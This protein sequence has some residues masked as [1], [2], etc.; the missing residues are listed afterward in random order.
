MLR[1]CSRLLAYAC[2]LFSVL[3]IGCGRSNPVS[4]ISTADSGIPVIELEYDPGSDWNRWRGPRGDGTAI[5]QSL[6]TEWDDSTNLRWR[7]DVPGRG[8]GSPIVIGSEVYLA[9]ANDE[10]QQQWVL[11]YDRETG[12]ELWRRLIHE[13]NFPTAR[14]VHK[15]ATN[16]NGTIASDGQ[17]LY[18]GMLNAG[19]I[20]ATA[21]DRG[22]KILW[23][24][25]A[26]KFVSRFGYAPSPLIYKSLVIFPADNEGGG[27]LTAFDGESGSVVWR[28]AR[29]DDTSYS[30]AQVASVGGRDQLLIAGGKTLSSYDPVTGETNWQ[31]PGIAASTCGTVVTSGDSIF[32]SGGYPQSETM[33]VDGNGKKV[34]SVPTKIYEPSPIVSGDYLVGVKDDGIAYCWSTDSGD[35]QWKKRLGGNF[36]ASPVIVNG[37]IYV[38][39]LNGETFVFRAGES[40]ELVAKNQ[41]GND[42][43]ASPAVSDGELF[44]RVGVGAG[45]GRKEQLICIGRES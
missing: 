7:A 35:L 8:H 42:C 18:I 27:H 13:G 32:A 6:P 14:E 39:N 24:N 33:C 15:K 4:E 40:F 12:D 11:A 2:L 17:R 3:M 41:L 19:A 23:Q 22:G 10:T 37:M 16:A 34:W 21:L 5:N 31:T 29:S 44:L 20:M 38:S 36:S 25:E 43:Y 45:S 26:G 28:I 30:S 9:T 1:I